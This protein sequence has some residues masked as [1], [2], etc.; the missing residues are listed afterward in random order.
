MNRISDCDCSFYRV[1]HPIMTLVLLPVLIL[2]NLSCVHVFLLLICCLVKVTSQNTV[3]EGLLE[4]D[5][6]IQNNL[7]FS[8]L[9][10]QQDLRDQYMDKN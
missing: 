9:S 4:T 6:P 8:E 5:S 7:T 1:T 10:L 3:D 2:N